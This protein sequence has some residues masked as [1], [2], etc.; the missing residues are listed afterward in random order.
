MMNSSLKLHG[1]NPDTEK[2]EKVKARKELR[3]T[4]RRAELER[5]R[6]TREPVKRTRTRGE[7][8]KRKG[9]STGQTKGRKIGFNGAGNHRK[10]QSGTTKRRRGD[11][12]GSSSKSE[13][14][15][16]EHASHVLPLG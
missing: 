5:K 2:R 8:Q 4:E 9:A 3:D 12:M 10:W 7:A 11:H 1:T 13:A 15:A 14:V 16:P 6:V